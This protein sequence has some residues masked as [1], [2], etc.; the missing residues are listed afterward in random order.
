VEDLAQ[1]AVVNGIDVGALKAVI[2]DIGADPA[3]ADVR[4]T[5]KT[6]WTGQTRSRSI[7]THYDLAGERIERDFAILADEPLE[8]LGS[9]TVPNPQE[10]LMA[11]VNACMTVGY[12]AGAAVRGITLD[13]LDI[14][15]TGALDLRGF[16]GIDE[17]VAPGYDQIDYAV[18]IAGSGTPEQFE[19]IHADVM[20]TSPN[21]YNMSKPVHMNGTLLLD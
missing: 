13:R 14:E 6:R 21:F 4:F 17:A 7:V 15:A 19:Q 18:R 10:L 8:L 2:A 5:V 9:N 12:V 16:L 3:K 1:P 11:A 20:K